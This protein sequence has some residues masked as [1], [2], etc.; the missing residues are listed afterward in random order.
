MKKAFTMIEIIFVISIIGILAAVIIPRT[1]SNKLNEAA[2]QVVS[3]IRYT[4]HLAIVDDKFNSN[5]AI[6]FKRR[7]Q[8]IFSNSTYTDNKPAYTI[9]SDTAGSASGNPDKSEIAKNPLD[10]S[11]ILSGGHSGTVNFTDPN[12]KKIITKEMNLGIA[13]GINSY[14][15]NGGCSGA[16][17]AFDHLGRPFGGNLSST[18]SAYHLGRLIKERCNIILTNNEGNITIAIEPESG[19]VHILR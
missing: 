15:L 12:D 13:Y 2:I 4:Q 17:I 10:S 19:Y 7:W 18:A 11:K 1:G 6:W 8:V 16:R 14:S 9:F 3:H 5:D